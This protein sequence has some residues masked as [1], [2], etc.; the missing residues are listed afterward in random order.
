M[1]QF[2]LVRSKKDKDCHTARFACGA[3]T[4]E[5]GA[6]PDVT[7]S[8]DIVDFVRLVKGQS[9]AALLYLGGLLRI[10]VPVADGACTVE[11]S[12]PKSSSATA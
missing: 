12:P 10:E 4:L 2:D 11:T 9:N 7:I 3:A 5:P 8:A 6:V 1:G